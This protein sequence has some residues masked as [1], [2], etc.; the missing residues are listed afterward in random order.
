MNYL[1]IILLI[2]F[3][4]SCFCEETNLLNELKKK[5]RHLSLKYHPDKQNYSKEISTI[6]FAEISNIYELLMD[7]VKENMDFGNKN[8]LEIYNSLE[9]KYKVLDKQYYNLIDEYNNLVEENIDLQNNI[10]QQ[11]KEYN[12]LIYKYNKL[13]NNFNHERR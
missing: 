7:S 4:V 10:K 11:N 8:N 13:V 12:N 9:K 2:A 3:I 6:L 5:Y 1:S